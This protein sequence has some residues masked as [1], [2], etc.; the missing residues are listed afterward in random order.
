MR[1]IIIA[2]AVIVLF[3]G[4]IKVSSYIAEKNARQREDTISV[5]NAGKLIKDLREMKD[6]H[7][8]DVRKKDEK[9]YDEYD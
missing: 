1:W 8:E 2:V 5:G 6:T 7:N 9:I 4:F 3:L